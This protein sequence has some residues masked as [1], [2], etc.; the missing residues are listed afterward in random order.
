MSTMVHPASLDVALG[1]RSYPIHIG[2]GV[3]DRAGSL[4][5]PCLRRPEVLLVT[6]EVVAGLEL[7]PRLEAS[8]EAAGRIVRKA[9]VPVGEEAKSFA[10]LGELCETLLRSGIERRS[11]ILA[12]GGGVVGDLAGFAAAVTLRGVD[13]VQI[14]TTLLAQV[15]SSVG[16]KTG[17]NLRA[18]KNLVGAFHQ[19]RAVLV[20]LDALKSLPPRQLRAG[21]AEIVKHAFIR[22]AAFFDFLETAGGRLLAGEPAPQARAISRSIAIKAEIVALDER[23][24]GELRALLNFGH[25]FAHAFETITGYGG[26]L[27]H[28]E[29]V[30][31]GMVC[32]FELSARLGHCPEPDARRAIE[33]LRRLGMPVLPGDLGLPGFR[34]A[35]VLEVM[36]R[37]KKVA[38]GKL[39]FVL[40]RAIGDAFLTDDVPETAI[41][42]LFDEHG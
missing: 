17:I 32:A 41:E 28:G 13:V 42:A 35:A 20:D 9:V 40:A 37:D 4:L 31:L 12:L 18:G 33:H 15:D 1:A 27:L 30:S 2:S 29:A 5:A 8:L 38:D 3:I 7:T 11:T 39:R 19:P 10:V 21:Y 25:T 6:D 26:K 23:E 24:T 16:G 22:D 14:P 36:R 34:A